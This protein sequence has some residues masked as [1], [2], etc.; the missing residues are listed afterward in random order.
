MAQRIVMQHVEVPASKTRYFNGVLDFVTT[1]TITQQK[2]NHCSSQRILAAGLSMEVASDGTPVPSRKLVRRAKRPADTNKIFE[3]GDVQPT[4]ARR[5]QPRI[6]G[7]ESAEVVMPDLSTPPGRSPRSTDRRQSVSCARCRIYNWK[8]HRFAKPA[9]VK[10]RRPP[11]ARNDQKKMSTASTSD[12]F[13]WNLSL[14][15]RRKRDSRSALPT[16]KTVVVPAP[17]RRVLRS[18]HLLENGVIGECAHEES[19]VPMSIGPSTSE[20]N[21]CVTET[22]GRSVTKASSKPAG[23]RRRKNGATTAS[24]S[25]ELTLSPQVDAEEVTRGTGRTNS[26]RI[27]GQAA[28][29]PLARTTREARVRSI[30]RNNDK[31]QQRSTAAGGRRSEAAVVKGVRS[32]VLTSARNVEGK[33]DA[34]KQCAQNEEKEKRQ[35]TELAKR[36]MEELMKGQSFAPVEMI[37]ADA[38]SKDPLGFV[39][40]LRDARLLRSLEKLAQLRQ[41]NVS[42]E[43][44]RSLMKQRKKE[45]KR[46][47]REKKKQK[48]LMKLAA[49]CGVS[50]DQL[51]FEMSRDRSDSRASAPGS[52]PLSLNGSLLGSANTS[53]PTV[54]SSAAL[55]NL[56]G[57]SPSS[58]LNVFPRPSFVPDPLNPSRNLAAE[59]TD[60][61]GADTPNADNYS[62]L[63]VPPTSIPTSNNHCVGPD[64]ASGFI[65][66]DD[67]NVNLANENA[68]NSKQC[69]DCSLKVGKGTEGGTNGNTPEDEEDEQNAIAISHLFPQFD[70]LQQLKLI[71]MCTDSKVQEVDEQEV[72]SMVL[73]PETGPS[74]KVAR[75][76]ALIKDKV[77]EFKE[78]NGMRRAISGGPTLQEGESRLE[79]S[80]EGIDVGNTAISDTSALEQVRQS[81][82]SSSWPIPEPAL[83]ASEPVDTHRTTD[84]QN[85]PQAH[86]NELSGEQFVSPF[87]STVQQPSTSTHADLSPMSSCITSMADMGFGLQPRMLS[88][89][90]EPLNPSPVDIH[91]PHRTPAVTLKEVYSFEEAFI[92]RVQ[93]PVDED[94]EN[95]Y[96]SEVKVVT[97]WFNHAPYGADKEAHI[98][99]WEDVRQRVLVADWIRKL[100]QHRADQVLLNRSRRRMHRKRDEMKT[101]EMRRS[102]STE[103]WWPRKLFEHYDGVLDLAGKVM[104]TADSSLTASDIQL[105]SVNNASL[106]VFPLD[107]D[108]TATLAYFRPGSPLTVSDPTDDYQEHVLA[109]DLDE[110]TVISVRRFILLGF[111]DA[112]VGAGRAM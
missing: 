66:N 67:Q 87:A 39:H 16:A 93:V 100:Q 74:N 63:A 78:I 57:P 3:G 64:H 81:A 84:L 94:E 75:T 50:I 82:M 55:S 5:K 105:P 10:E 65:V 111:V 89:L 86:S 77:K 4:V 101:K 76:L 91:P 9:V 6:V 54:L 58:Y 12:T 60:S 96:M 90:D 106:K 103:A 30:G 107:D 33:E 69:G 15:E 80:D 47:K 70:A 29:M 48:R 104:R 73:R 20:V 31:E 26:K 14:E 25:A 11:A 23:A 49:N 62:P 85:S 61:S 71:K 13:S 110:A 7:D 72:V 45:K 40:S 18:D 52:S 112:F 92:N 108:E 95:I 83:T 42:A 37:V 88:I 41:L 98:R 28:P 43:E 34:E 56:P 99:Y 109:Q 102:K 27:M 8:E 44:A 22:P 68:Q 2:L 97:D 51:E 79:S 46:E 38:I 21:C 17:S 35:R 1:L 36:A 32:E 24:S 59:R 53:T 19:A